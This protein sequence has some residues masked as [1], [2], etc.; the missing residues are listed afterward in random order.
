MAIVKLT[1]DQVTVIDDA[2]VPLVDGWSWQ[3]NPQK[4]KSGV[5]WYARGRVDGKLT[6]LHRFLLGLMPGDPQ[7]DHR[8]RDGLDNRRKN[9]RLATR[10]QN[11]ANSNGNPTRRKSQY[12]G[13]CWHKNR[14]WCAQITVNGKHITRF[15]R[16]E[17]EAAEEYKR[18]ASELFGEF[19]RL[20]EVARPE[21]LRER[22]T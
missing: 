3:A 7:V 18:L 20:C 11:L 12:K 22:K 17:V 16:T 5:L 8:N 19:A 14:R 1:R 4:R 15:A 13:V 21:I 9:L 10:S 6:Y 2:D